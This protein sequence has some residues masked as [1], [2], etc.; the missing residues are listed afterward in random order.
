MRAK[1][2]DITQAE[3]LTKSNRRASADGPARE[4]NLVIDDPIR[5][6]LA[7]IGAQPL[8]DRAQESAVAKRLNAARRRFRRALLGSDFVL[9]EV[10]G[11]LKRVR[12]G[13]ARIDRVLDVSASDAARKESLRGP[14][15]A[16]LATLEC[17]LHLNHGDFRLAAGKRLPLD[18]RRQVW[19]KMMARRGRAVSLV[20]ELPI[21]TKLLL[22]LLEKLSQ[23]SRR[24]DRLYHRL[25]S[26]GAANAAAQNDESLSAAA[27]AIRCA[28]RFLMQVTGESPATL[29]KRLAR[30]RRLEADYAAAKRE[31]CAA[32]LRLVV[33]VAKHY[34]CPGMTLLDLIQEGNAGLMRAVDKFEVGRGFKFSTYATWW[35]RQSITRAIAEQ[36]HAVVLPAQQSETLRKV[37][38]AASRLRQQLGHDASCDDIAGAVGLSPQQAAA[39][40]KL[41][42]LLAPPLSLDQP[43]QGDNGSMF[44]DFLADH[45]AESPGASAMRELLKQ[46]INEALA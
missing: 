31:L 21:R 32:N 12:D 40:L 10:V 37:R 28:L 15:V 16:N 14:L 42:A 7:Q 35:I 38:R 5:L 22:P 44:G 19:R 46:R 23:L 9:A 18:E 11:D 8:L 25:R 6:Y 3:S 34:Q 43:I 29:R 39:A 20:E 1:P 45:R 13:V 27:D 17:L 36:S 4:A 33:S 24:M 2:R 41:L 30:I 26:M